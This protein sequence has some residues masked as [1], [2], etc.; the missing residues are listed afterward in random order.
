MRCSPT[1]RVNSRPPKGIDSRPAILEPGQMLTAIARYIK[2]SGGRR[3]GQPGQVLL[4]SAL[5]FIVLIGIAGLA[6]DGGRA[7][8][9]RRSLQSAADSG[10]DSAM[11]MIL[12]DFRD[13][14]NGGAPQTFSDCN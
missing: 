9:N 4:L 10:A 14:E 2:P 12:Q 11:R 1:F 7:Y 3:A 6:V 8:V 5:A 13:F